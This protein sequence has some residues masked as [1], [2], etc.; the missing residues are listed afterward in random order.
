MTADDGGKP[1]APESAAGSVANL[2]LRSLRSGR[3][4]LTKAEG[5]RCAECAAVCLESMGHGRQTALL[6]TGRH[7]AEFQVTSFTVTAQ[8]RRSCGDT[9][10]TTEYGASAVAALMIEC[11]GGL[12]IYERSP[13]NGGGYDYYLIR[14]D[15]SAG[16]Y[17]D[18]NFLAAPTALLEVSGIRRGPDEVVGRVRQK[19]ARLGRAVTT[20]PAWVIVVEFSVPTAMVAHL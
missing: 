15:E 9:E 5:T 2:D 12:T 13:K 6:V 17:G 11:L 4:G 10:V 18:D 16:D 3:Y 20:L 7:R 8:M 1:A 14:L 19:I